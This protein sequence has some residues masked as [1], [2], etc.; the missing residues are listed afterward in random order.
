MSDKII[1][2]SD[3][4]NKKDL[5]VILEVNKKAIELET[6]MVD[7]NEEIIKVLLELKEKQV[8]LETSFTEIEETLS[9]MDEEIKED[10]TEINKNLFKIQVLFITG[11]LSLIVQII[12]M[13][14]K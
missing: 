7:Q 8:D 12:Q 6:E 3:H 2:I 1:S 9:K 4:I 10:I 11:L 13:I 14:K 5:E